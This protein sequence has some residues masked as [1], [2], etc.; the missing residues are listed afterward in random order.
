MEEDS[1]A[2]SA[3]S[4][5]IVLETQKKSSYLTAVKQDFLMDAK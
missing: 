1:A 2:V 5:H 3:P 4:G